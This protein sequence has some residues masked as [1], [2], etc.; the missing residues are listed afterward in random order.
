METGKV[1]QDTFQET[2]CQD[3]REYCRRQDF[4]ATPEGF[5]SYMID[6]DIIPAVSIKR[7]TIRREY[8]K[9]HTKQSDKKTRTVHF[10]SDRFNISPRTVW[11]ILKRERM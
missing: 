1:L 11:A 5:V 7:Y 8:Q 4:E 9:N 3:Y 6:K 2:L 10:L